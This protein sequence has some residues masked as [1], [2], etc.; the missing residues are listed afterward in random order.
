MPQDQFLHHCR[1]VRLP[2][3]KIFGSV[4]TEKIFQN[5]SS[6]IHLISGGLGGFGL[7]LADWLVLRGAR[8]LVLSSRK[9]LQSGYQSYKIML[10]RSYGVNVAISN[11][12]VTT[13][14]GVSK[15]LQIANDLGPVNG[16]F[17]LAVVLDTNTFKSYIRV[18][19]RCL[20]I[21]NIL[22]LHRS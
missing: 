18:P 15:L 13:E 14:T 12:D 9:G 3:L 17:N 8:N 16:I 2:F 22:F 4:I 5:D 7:E 20:Y 11:E 1:L 6:T 19:K 21:I 10:W